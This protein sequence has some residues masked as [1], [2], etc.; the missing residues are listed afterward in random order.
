MDITVS[1]LI[2]TEDFRSPFR[3]VDGFTERWWNDNHRIGRVSNQKS[4]L[5][6]FVRDGEELARAEVDRGTIGNIYVDLT[7]AE[8]I[9][10][11]VFFEVHEA[12]RG[13]GIGRAAIELI[14]QQYPDDMVIAF[15]EEADDFWSGIGW[16]HHPR[17]EDPEMYRSL[18]VHDARRQLR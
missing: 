8:E 10:D 12:H 17:V 13:K 15:S 2:Q 18:F 11:I 16:K 14:L 4:Q 9:V 6:S 1:E 5:F 7:P 3:F